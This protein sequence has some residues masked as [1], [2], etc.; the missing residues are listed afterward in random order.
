MR[1]FG[2]T[3]QNMSTNYDKANL[4]TSIASLIVAIIAIIISIYAICSQEDIAEKSGAFDKSDLKLSFGEYHLSED[5]DYDINYGISFS[6]NTANFV[7]LPLMVSN[8]GRKSA[9][10]LEVFYKYPYESHI[11]VDSM[12]LNIE[13]LKSGLSRKT[14]NYPPFGQTTLYTDAIN[15]NI[16]IRIGDVIN[17]QDETKM[18]IDY[19]TK[20]KDSIDVN[21][22]AEAIYSIITQVA[23]TAKDNIAK[24]YRFNLG[25]YNTIDYKNLAKTIITN[26]VKSK[27]LKSFFIVIPTNNTP[28]KFKNPNRVINQYRSEEIYYYYFNNIKNQ[29]E[30]IT[31]NGEIREIIELQHLRK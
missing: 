3:N 16:S 19:P 20:T 8:E 26:N 2:K 9:E 1:M 10:N 17:L 14:N 21:I 29:Y 5:M 31:S 13:S 25:T 24:S 30:S 15:P 23:I 12:Y 28:I 22:K 27:D 6:N 11:L 18:L 7:S 4:R